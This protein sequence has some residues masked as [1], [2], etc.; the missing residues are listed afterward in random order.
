MAYDLLIKNGRI[1]DGSGMPAFRGDVGIRNGKIAELGKLGG[2]AQRT[3]DA[4]GQVVAPGFVDNHCHF[5]AQ[6]TWDPLCSFSP[7]H[8]ATTVVFG[9]CSLGL[10]PIRP[11][12]A[13]R[14]AEFLSYV[15]AIPMNV[16]D[17]VDVEW[18]SIAQYM[19]RL[20]GRLGVNVGNLIGHTTVRYYVMGDASQERTATSDEIKAMQDVVRDG[21]KAGA[22]GLS[23]S[24]NRGHYDPQGKHIPALWA[25]EAEIFALADV[26]RELGTGIVQCGGGRAPELKD[27]L[28]AR[29]SEATGR[30][31]IYNNLGQTMR[32]PDAWKKHMARLE[33][34][35][36][37][38]IRAFPLCSPN[39][40][41][42]HF[43]MKNCQ[44]FRGT[45]TWHP[46]LLASD[47]EKLRAYSDPAVRR[48][49]HEEVV[50][51][52][53]TKLPA[54]G[55]SLKWWDY[56][57]VE[58]P[59]LEK[60]KG[61]KGKTIGQLAKDQ[62]KGVIDAFLDLVVEEKLETEFMQSEINVDNEAMKQIL[63]HPNAIVGLS[64]GGAHV[65]FHGGYGYCTR[66]L[67]EWVREKKIMT[68]EHAVRRLTFDSASA[69]GLYDRGLLRP[70][71]NADVV[72]FDSDTVR[73]LPESIV[74][75]FPAGGWRVK[76]PAAGVMATIVNGEVLLENGEHTGA[77][78]G[79]VA[80]NTY[81]HANGA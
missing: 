62:G 37:A 48:K 12:T 52:K 60:N 13:K 74:H 5:D 40:T 66:L 34:T 80:R 45:P 56:M 61:L 58:K 65:Q 77:L 71:L 30:T 25:D 19:N 64:D 3:I 41:T 72:I 22:L 54:P 67:A 73:P 2:P 53:G 10:A 32:D 29:L 49:L 78:P 79:K 63:S 50:E 59:A 47:E 57:W 15:E 24:R 26:L 38:G 51:H 81:Y 16:L 28:M 31:V 43:T 33:E 27:G 18:E 75:D 36:K 8:G 55:Y 35:S 11:G 42:Q 9:N 69:L 20:E 17:T 68:L 76:E 46:I 23:V 6:V 21:M 44:V 14:V 70:G 1:V 39:R 7:Q 4:E